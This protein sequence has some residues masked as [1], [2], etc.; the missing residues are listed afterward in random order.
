MLFPKKPLYCNTSSFQ[1]S[2]SCA[3]ETVGCLKSLK[4]NTKQT[5]VDVSDL[6]NEHSG[7]TVEERLLREKSEMVKVLQTQWKEIIVSSFIVYI[8]F[9]SFFLK[10]LLLNK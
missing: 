3:N 4:M 9:Y 5:R 1:L 10:L 6:F 7:E 8:R 2:N